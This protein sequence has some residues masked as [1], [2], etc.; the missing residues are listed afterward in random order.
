MPHQRIT[1]CVDDASMMAVE[2]AATRQFGHV[3]GLPQTQL[4][5]ILP[6]QSDFN[7]SSA[8]GLNWREI[9]FSRN[10]D[11][12]PP[13][14]PEQQSPG[15]PQQ[16]PMPTPAPQA[17]GQPASGMSLIGSD[18]AIIGSGLK[19]VAQQTLQVDGEVQGDVLG[20][21]IIIG[22]SGKVTGLV[23]AEQVQVNGAVYGTIKAVEVT[24][25]SNAVVEGD[26]F[27][28]TIVL[29]QGA[30]FE[31]RSRRPKER[32]ELMPDLRVSDP[33]QGGVAAGGGQAPGVEAPLNGRG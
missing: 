30:S 11:K 9:M 25:A 22:H 8:N 24:L 16:R 5:T 23:N 32:E 1:F 27:H 18:L 3:C 28:Q 20:A 26:I 13:R 10:S 12:D 2:A 7:V 19:I 29:E 15:I 17:S 14:L 4:D 21:R 33:N 6:L 31:G